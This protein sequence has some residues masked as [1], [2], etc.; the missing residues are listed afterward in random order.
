MLNSGSTR[1]I[2]AASS[3]NGW[4]RLP[5]AGRRANPVSA[6]SS[7]ERDAI[8]VA[9]LISGATAADVAV[10]APERPEYRTDYQAELMAGY[11]A[12]T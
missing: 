4:L 10:S 3:T 1:L 6:E 12:Q 11:L 9:R 5:S 2:S 8:A 7:L